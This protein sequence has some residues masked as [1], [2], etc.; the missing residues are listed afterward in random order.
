MS[1]PTLPSPQSGQVVT[2]PRVRARDRNQDAPG[3]ERESAP[4]LLP[5]QS[6]VL[7][8]AGGLGTRLRSA[9]GIGQKVLAPVGGQP[10]LDKILSRL[11]HAGFR[12]VVLCTGYRSEDVQ[13]RYG[14][15]YGEMELRYSEEEV[16]LGTGGGTSLGDRVRA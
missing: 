4:L 14:H 5:S 13:R 15:E 8:L 2:K 6:A 1:E 9:T 3:R 10:F 7:I 12:E 16:P 11:D